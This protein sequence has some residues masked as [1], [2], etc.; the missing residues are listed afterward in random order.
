MNLHRGGHRWGQMLLRGATQQEG[1]ANEGNDGAVGASQQKLVSQTY[2]PT[3]CCGVLR[4]FL[5]VCLQGR[6]SESRQCGGVCRHRMQ[7]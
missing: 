4:G 3:T 6:R 7:V 2:I 1:E 5:A